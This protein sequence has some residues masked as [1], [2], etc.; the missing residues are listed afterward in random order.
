MGNA[1]TAN[2]GQA[3]SRFAKLYLKLLKEATQRERRYVNSSLMAPLIMVMVV[4]T[5]GIMMMLMKMVMEAAQR[6]MSIPV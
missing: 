6:G 2:P 1:D 5:M 3:R 4:M